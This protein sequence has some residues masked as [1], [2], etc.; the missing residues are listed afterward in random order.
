ML[1]T[2]S[3]AIASARFLG[4]VTTCLVALAPAPQSVRASVPRVDIV[5]R[6][7]AIVAGLA[8]AVCVVAPIGHFLGAPVWITGL[9]WF[10]ALALTVRTVYRV[11]EGAIGRWTSQR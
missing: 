2:T 4:Y 6:S 9:G 5:A 3:T 7:L 1:T 10:L 11:C 8:V